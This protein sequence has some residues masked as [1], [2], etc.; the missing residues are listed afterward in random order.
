VFGVSLK[1]DLLITIVFQRRIEEARNA[2]VNQIFQ[3][4]VNG[5]ILVNANGNRA[6]EWKMFED[7]IVAGGVGGRGKGCFRCHGVWTVRLH[8]RSQ[9]RFEP[10]ALGRQ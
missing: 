6:N 1:S 5:K 4:D 9:K 10:Q 2:G 8:G 7:E 3:V